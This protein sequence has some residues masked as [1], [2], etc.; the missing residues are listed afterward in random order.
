MPRNHPT[1]EQVRTG[2][3]VEDIILEAER[4]WEEHPERYEEDER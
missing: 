3:Y 4:D 1:P 2:H